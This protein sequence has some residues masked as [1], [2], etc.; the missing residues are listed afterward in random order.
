MKYR[1]RITGQI[2]TLFELQQKF[3]NV[4][5]PQSWSNETYDFANVDPVVET[6][7]PPE[8]NIRNRVDFAGVQLVDDVWTETWIEVPK[9][10]NP[11]QQAEW[12]AACLET[13]WDKVRDERNRLLVVTDYTQF[14]DTPITIQSKAEFVVYRQALRD[15]TT[16]SD[17]NNII[18]PTSP[19]YQKE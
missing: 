1:D 7:Q 10:D 6:P 18:W 9:Y 11:T 14:P 5:F 16:Q 4:S 13:E 15:I 3:S 8:T 19:I 17:P 12:E 2:Y